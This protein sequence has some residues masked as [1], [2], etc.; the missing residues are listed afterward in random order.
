MVPPDATAG[1][2]YTTDITFWLPPTFTDPGSG[3]S[4]SFQQMTITGVSG[5]PFGMSMTPSEPSGVYYPQQ[6]EHGCARLCGTPLGAGSFPITI[7]I[8]ASVVVSGFSIDVPQQFSIVLNVLPGSGSNTGFSFSPISGCGTVSAT[9]EALIDGAPLPTTWLW[10]FGNGGA[11]DLAVPPSQTY[12]E[13]GTYVISLTTTIGGFVLNTVSLTGVNGNWC[14]DVEEPNLPLVGCTGSPDLYFVLTDASGSTVVSQTFDN[15]FTATWSDLGIV[16]DN[17]PYSISFHDEDVISQNDL[18]GTYNIPPNGAGTYFINVAGGTT[19]GLE[20]GLE[21]LQVFMDQ[22]TL[23]VLPVPEFSL[24]ENPATGELCALVDTLVSYVWLL[25]GDTVASASGPCS[26]PGD[27][28]QWSVIGTN[29]FGCSSIS[30]VVIVCPQVVIVREGNVLSVPGGYLNYSWTLDGTPIGAD[31]PFLITQVDGTYS[32]SM[33]GPNGCIMTAEFVLNTV[34]I[35]VSADQEA[36]LSLHPNPSNGLF[37]AVASGLPSGTAA[38]LVRDD[39]GR[40]VAEGSVP[41]VSGSLRQAMVLDLAPGPYHVE[42][43]IRD[44]SIIS[45]LIVY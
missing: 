6:T 5:L 19:G 44:R 21:T 18:L 13:P 37:T 34:G 45:S 23:V 15:T 12:T 7:N 26:M 30:N 38:I 43:R 8:L 36:A 22:D 2:Y 39:R 17:A 3:A 28:G 40:T 10:D 32:V 42:V 16:L 29:A 35:Q 11:S 20:I 41:V 9:F 24:I 4:V 31:Q 33:D 27:P 1:T 14:G 25:D